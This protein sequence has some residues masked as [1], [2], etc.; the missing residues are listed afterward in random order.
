[1]TPAPV[2]PPELLRSGALFQLNRQE[3]LREVRKIR[4]ELG[5]CSG[6]MRSCMH[7]FG[8]DGGARDTIG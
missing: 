5:T 3:H 7:E 1:M 6:L 2:A 4:D 8:G